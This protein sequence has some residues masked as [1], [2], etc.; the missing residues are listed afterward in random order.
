MRGSFRSWSNLYFLVCFWC[1]YGFRVA[2]IV[3][4]VK[5]R[6]H[7]C[8]RTFKVKRRSVVIEFDEDNGSQK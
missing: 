3:M 6:F 4:N 8:P 7:N 5:V 1:S 2:G